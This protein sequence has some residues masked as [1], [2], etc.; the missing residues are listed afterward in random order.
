MRTPRFTLIA[1]LGRCCTLST[2]AVP[3]GPR[4]PPLTPTNGLEHNA[5]SI[6]VRLG[7]QTSN[8]IKIIENKFRK[9]RN[10]I[11]LGDDLRS[12]DAQ[13]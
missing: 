4:S 5:A 11:D 9:I 3:V 1:V 13:K 8:K 2:G 6:S 10:R 12:A 7:Y